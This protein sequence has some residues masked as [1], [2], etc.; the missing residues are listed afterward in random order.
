M[1]QA[2]PRPDASDSARVEQDRTL[3]AICDHLRAGGGVWLFLDYDGTMVPIARTPDQAIADAPLLQLLTLL[4][5]TPG[6]RTAVI[7]GRALGS[8]Q[9]LLHIPGLTLAGLYGAEIQMPDGSVVRRG[10]IAD[11]RQQLDTIR[12]AWTELIDHRAGFLIEDKGLSVALHGSLADA[13]DANQVLPRARDVIG[14]LPTSAFR[15]LG[16][17]RFLEVAPALAHKGAT[18]AWLLDHLPLPDALPVYFGDDDKDAE[19]FPVIHARGG[20]PVVVGTH[21]E[22]STAVARLA[23]PA[24]A[25]AWLEKI[26]AV[27]ED[28]FESQHG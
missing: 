15:I 12:R 7:S 8:L 1:D 24:Q 13:R 5:R 25:R 28:A 20:I 27:A 2:V 6:V 11:I 23:S 22:A 16:G 18:V 19:A 17:E 10:E 4:A 21:L 3:A 26:H 14:A 9:V